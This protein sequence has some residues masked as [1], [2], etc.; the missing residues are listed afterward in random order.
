M[1]NFL[2]TGLVL[3]LSSFLTTAIG[4]PFLSDS[5]AR[6]LAVA[7]TIR[8]YHAY[9]GHQSHIYTGIEH[10]PYLPLAKG[11][12]YFAVDSLRSGDIVYD[13]ILY[14]N[15]PMQYD[16]VRDMVMVRNHA[17]NYLCPANS[18]IQRFTLD[19]HVFVN[20]TNGFY[21]VL[22]SGKI[23]IYARRTKLIEEV[24]VGMELTRNIISR[25]RYY[26]VD[27]NNVYTPVNTRSSLFA[28]FGE[29]KKEIRQYLRKNNI[30]VRRNYEEALAKATQYYNQLSR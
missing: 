4:Q 15:V 7:Q 27:A 3:S 28:L 14:E 8:A 5:N 13:G 18:S 23:T 16:L 9:M 30:N 29:R 21:D 22:S 11:Q 17:G 12:P 25:E 1:R 6:Q 2:I 10:V 19:G 20:T 26:R 24:I